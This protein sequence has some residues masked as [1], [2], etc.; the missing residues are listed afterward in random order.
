VNTLGKFPA[1]IR[2]L[3]TGVVHAT[4]GKP[5]NRHEVE[6][7][8]PLGLGHLDDGDG[9]LEVLGAVVDVGEAAGL[10]DRVSMTTL[11]VSRWVR[12]SISSGVAQSLG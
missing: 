8:L 9:L 11:K 1:H 10:F 7:N 4:L 2:P 12:V 5:G 6:R 3:T